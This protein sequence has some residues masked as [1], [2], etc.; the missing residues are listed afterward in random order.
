MKTSALTP[1][2]S[3]IMNL[4]W[5]R[6]VTAEIRLMR[7]RA[8]VLNTTGVSPFLARCGRHDD[9]SAYAP[10]RRNRCRLLILDYPEEQPERTSAI[11]RD[12]AERKT[13]PFP[14]RVLFL[15]RRSFAQWQ[16]ETTILQGRFG[17]QEIAAP[18]PLS[19]DDGLKVIAE[20]ARN[21]ATHANK[22]VPDFG[23]A[24]QWLGASPSHRL[25]LYAI[26]SSIHAVLSPKK[27]FGL[28]SGELL[29][30]LA[31]REIDRVRPI[32]VSLGPGGHGLGVPLAVG[33]LADG[34]S[35][36]AIKELVA[37]GACE[38]GGRILLRLWRT[39]RGG[40]VAA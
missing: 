15:S 3:L 7:Y 8:P 32:S 19:I 31:Q 22:P 1:P 30:N 16:G 37:A 2:F 34:L 40:N 27:A 21:F 36:S 14:L 28:G 18:A 6:E 11:L 29:N 26:A 35:E 23:A 25:P 13:A 5:P 38:G 10:H 33:V 4:I 9:R 39:A 12:L 17:R 24:W 20:T